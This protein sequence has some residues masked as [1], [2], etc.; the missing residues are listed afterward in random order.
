M[1]AALLV[2]LRAQYIPEETKTPE[3]SESDKVRRY[4]AILR[5]GR[6][7]EQ[8]YAQAVNLHEIQELMMVAAKGLATLEGTVEARQLVWGIA[9]RLANS[10][11]PPES[12]VVAEMLLM[13]ARIDE[14]AD[15]PAEA[16]DELATFVARYRGTPG[17]AKALL[18]ASELCR[19]AD[20][21]APRHAYLQQLSEKH[22]SAPG[23]SEFLEVEGVNPY[24]GRLMTAKLVRPDG[25]TLTLPRDLLGKCTVVQFW[26]MAKSGMVDLTAKGAVS[27]WPHYKPFR[28][29]GV[30]FVGVNLDTDRA[31]VARFVREE[32]EGIDWIQ[33]CSGLGL[34]DPMF[35]RYRVSTLPAYWLIGPNGCVISNSY[36]RGVQQWPQYS[37]AVNNSVAQFDE[38]VMRMPYYRS[39]EF[40]LD[41]PSPVLGS[42]AGGEGN[43]GG[44]GKA[45]GEGNSLP[46]P[47]LGR[48]AGG[49]GNDD[50]PA[51]QL[52]EF[53]RKVLL[54]PALGLSKDKKAAAFR[55]T[56]EL[57]RSIE[58]KY[59][60]AANLPVVWNGML[61]AA[62]WLATETQDKISDKALAKQAQEIAERIL[63]SKAQGS[64]RLLADYVQVAG[65]LAAS[66]FSREES[67][68]RINALVEQ[69]AHDELHWA[70]AILGVF[71]ATECGDEGTRGSLVAELRG[72]E[73]RQP[74]VRG[75]LR[76]FCN[77][78]LDARTTQAQPFP[79]PGGTVPWEV[80]GELPL[81]GGGTLRLEDLKEKMVMIHF[82]SI[83]CPAFAPSDK[84]PPPRGPPGMSPEPNWD[85]V[86]VGVNLDRSRDEVE[87]YLK[88]H[89][90]YKG[91]IHVFSG[92]GQDD[93]LARQLDIYGMPRSVLL[94][95]DGLIYRWGRLTQMG[96][97]VNYRG[98]AARPRPKPTP[99]PGS[100]KI[101]PSIPANQG[102]AGAAG[103]QLPKEITL[104]LGG[105]VAMKLALLPAGDFRMGTPQTEKWH[106]ED[107]TP[108]RRKSL[109]KPFYMGIHHVTRGQ[110]AAFV[111]QT[112]Y[113]TEA[114]QEGWSLLWNGSWQK[115][116]GA[117]WRKPGFDQDDGHPVVCVS[118]ND[119]VEFCN[120]LGRTSRKTVALPTEARWEYACRAGTETVYP[121]GS[122]PEEGNGWCNAADRSAAKKLPGWTTFPWDDGY[123]F[124]SPSGKFKANAFGLYDMTGN[125]WQWCD[126]WYYQ[127]YLKEREPRNDPLGPPSGTYRVTRGGSWHSGPDYCRS[128]V[129]RKEPPATRNDMLGFR[130]VVEIP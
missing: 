126:D 125:A 103:D 113:K 80:R 104:D 114:E 74:R 28:E 45:G 72:D 42:R 94:D 124:T 24:L 71:L 83:A 65:E 43:T 102:T 62:R 130:V 36:Q 17:E 88:Q 68:R 75:F 49:E 2:R 98:M 50:I 67:A 89:E 70:A 46:S 47:V 109:T 53:R 101:A 129:R 5:E 59:E 90:Q 95:R 15:W 26:S 30:E 19:I 11:A 40:L 32:C 115:V 14:L 54:P 25:S 93:P 55:E 58:K 63:K 112:H 66:E 118:W 37:N 20:A 79:Q 3:I 64:Q 120:W 123:L 92:L 77:L 21:D 1:P 18:G 73:A 44:E 117:S 34:K 107:E 110:F 60:R 61:V 100:P 38:M 87:K 9:R 27:L 82:W 108:P 81:L 6:W 31:Q 4:E 78:N 7:A 96:N 41:L 22:F 86:V 99:A 39:G 122:R 57:G 116:E 16:A 127:D 8:Q 48:G 91:W 51:E 35:Q 33:T 76:D 10:S 119:A 106:F 85:L 105:K 84:M 29:A 56:L 111:Q 13:R 121:W 128:A 69:Y 12:R 52:D 97:N 23:V